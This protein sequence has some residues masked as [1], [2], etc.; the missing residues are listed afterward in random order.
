MEERATAGWRVGLV[1]LA[2]A[3]ATRAQSEDRAAQDAFDRAAQLAAKGSYQAAHSAYREIAERWPNTKAGRRAQKRSQPTACLGWA[4]IVENGPAQNRVDVVL[5]GDGF[6]LDEQN[7]FDDMAKTVP[8]TFAKNEVLGEYASYFNFLRLNLASKDGDIDAYGREYE[9][10][11]DSA[12]MG[13]NAPW[14]RTNPGKVRDML[15]ELPAHDGQALVLVKAQGFHG[16]GGGGIGIIAGREDQ[17]IVHEFG[18]SFG[19][20]GDEYST[21][22]FERG[23]VGR[24]P[25]VSP[26]DDP[27][28]V[29]WKHWLA[30]NA[31]G[32][33]IYRG[34]A[35]RLKGAWKPVA[36]GCLM[37]SGNR[38]CRVC[39]EAV[40]LRIHDFVDPI[41]ACEPPAHTKATA[42]AVRPDRDGRFRFTVEILEPKSHGL[43]VTWF[44]LP[45]SSAPPPPRRLEAGEPRRARGPLPAIDH[46][47]ALRTA[48]ARG[49]VQQFAWR[50]DRREQGRFLVVCRVRDLA[51]VDGQSWAWVLRDEHGVLES[52]RAWWVEVGG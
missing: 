51:K 26:T 48:D 4:W 40:V 23:E 17:T 46:K 43:E 42:Q 1:A 27:D 34:G 37:E 21:F 11:L 6:T 7:R 8:K 2:L 30:A 35:G 44:V 22:T 39:R 13:N 12:I 41:D 33:G 24:S 19:G 28:Q 29:P 45:Q 18:H 9:T 5:M 15:G 3:A 14:L 52:E 38:F 10:A 36:D 49:R 16:T 50:P 20:L 47:P 32:V 31:P 25:N